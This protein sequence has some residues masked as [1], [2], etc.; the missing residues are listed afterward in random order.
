MSDR[1]AA[2]NVGH[3]GRICVDSVLRTSTSLTATYSR[4]FSETYETPRTSPYRIRRLSTTS[5]FECVAGRRANFFLTAKLPAE[6]L[7]LSDASQQRRSRDSSRFM[8]PLL[9]LL[10]CC[11]FVAGPP[12]GN[13]IPWRH[14]VRAARWKDVPIPPPAPSPEDWCGAWS[15][16]DDLEG[17]SMTEHIYIYA[18]AG[19]W[20][21]TPI[22]A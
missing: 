17:L 6:E 22:R 12:F 13:V 18:T 2:R 1:C 11:T 9:L 19:R 3:F 10:C 7:L 8:I 15:P 20:A 5:P 14:A 16:Y 21:W 4:R